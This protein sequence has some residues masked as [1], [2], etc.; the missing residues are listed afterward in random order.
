MYFLTRVY[1]TTP[2]HKLKTF[3]ILTFSARAP[4]RGI[5]TGIMIFTYQDMKHELIFIEH[6]FQ[7]RTSCL[8]RLPLSTLFHIQYDH[9]HDHRHIFYSLVVKFRLLNTYVLEIH[10][11]RPCHSLFS[12]S[13][14]LSG[15][16]ELCPRFDYHNSSPISALPQSIARELCDSQHAYLSKSC[17][18]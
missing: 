4:S 6:V 9:G 15:S 10:E 3:R 17:W 13:E 14:Y 16:R 1:S 2:L 8:G 12:A 5:A 18:R 11:D 7:L